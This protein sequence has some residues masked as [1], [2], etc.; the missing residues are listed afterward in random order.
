MDLDQSTMIL[1]LFRHDSIVLDS[2]Q[3]IG[4]DSVGFSSFFHKKK[5]IQIEKSHFSIASINRRYC[6][7]AFCY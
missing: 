5:Q 6:V 1:S 4:A 2:M 3:E 7:V